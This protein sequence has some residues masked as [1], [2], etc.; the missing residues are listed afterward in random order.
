MRFIVG[1]RPG[2]G[3]LSAGRYVTQNK[4]PEPNKIAGA[5][6]A[7]ATGFAALDSGSFMLLFPVSE[8]R[9][10]GRTVSGDPVN[11]LNQCEKKLRY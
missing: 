10:F 7:E 1:S 11:C 3:P 6:A 8:T 4:Q 5:N 9:S 2:K